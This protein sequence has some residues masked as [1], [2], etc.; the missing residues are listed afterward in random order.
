MTQFT[1]VVAAMSP[2]E[3][4]AT[5]DAGLQTMAVTRWLTLRCIEDLDASQWVQQVAPGS[6]HALFNVGHVA[7]CDASFLRA[8]GGE[9]DA[10]PERYAQ[11]FEA[12][13]E[14]QW[15]AAA[16]PPAAELVGVFGRAREALD[17]HL[18]GLGDERLLAAPAEPRLADV[19]PTL[20]HLP[21]FI[22]MHE[23]THTGQ[24]LLLRRAL[25]LPRVLGRANE[26]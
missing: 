13:C 24:I 21:G 9:T 10:V 17:A 14:P 3:A 6:N 23:G 22:A 5:C 2:A 12:G 25:G 16:Y 8:A 20:A 1:D 19:V 15:D 18:R 4:R 7:L 26:S 11:L